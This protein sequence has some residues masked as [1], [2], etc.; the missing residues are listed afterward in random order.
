MKVMKTG[1]IFDCIYTRSYAEDDYLF[2]DFIETLL[3][4]L[5]WTMFE[6]QEDICYNISEKNPPMLKDNVIEYMENALNNKLGWIRDYVICHMLIT[7]RL[8]NVDLGEEAE[9]NLRDSLGENMWKD[10]NEKAKEYIWADYAKYL[11][12]DKAA[13]YFKQIGRSEYIPEEFNE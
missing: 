6:H 12:A 13:E 9:W 11:G 1:E 7:Y 8:S 4:D 5:S 10:F 2:N 3:C